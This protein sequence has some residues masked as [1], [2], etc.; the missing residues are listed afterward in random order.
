[1]G[2]P[3]ERAFVVA[4][5]VSR[6]FVCALPQGALVDDFISFTSFRSVVAKLAIVRLPSGNLEH[7]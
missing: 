5:A 3:T 2:A 1:M 7:T 6:S 4:S